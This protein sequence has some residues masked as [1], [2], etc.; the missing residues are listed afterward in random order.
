MLNY[1]YIDININILPEHVSINDR[2]L[3]NYKQ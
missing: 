2:L 3:T 1:V